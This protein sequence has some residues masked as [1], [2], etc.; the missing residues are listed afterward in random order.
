[1]SSFSW[2]YTYSFYQSY[3]LF[4][5]QVFSDFSEADSIHTSVQPVDLPHLEITVLGVV[6]GFKATPPVLLE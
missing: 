3:F 6:Q 4:H 5:L 2:E 1:M